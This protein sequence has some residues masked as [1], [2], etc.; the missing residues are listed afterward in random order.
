MII[1]GSGKDNGLK[2]PYRKPMV[3]GSS[4]FLVENLYGSGC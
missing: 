1:G 4:L 3:D 2:K